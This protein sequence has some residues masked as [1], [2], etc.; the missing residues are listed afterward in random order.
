LQRRVH[1]RRVARHAIVFADPICRP[2][3]VS[4]IWTI[5]AHRPQQTDQAQHLVPEYI[6]AA[7]LG[8]VFVGIAKAREISGYRGDLV[9]LRDS[10]ADEHVLLIVVQKAW[11]WRR[12]TLERELSQ[13]PRAET[14]DGADIGLVESDGIVETP[15]ADEPGTYA[16]F[17]L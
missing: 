13:Q 17:Q 9:S 7:L 3:C 14:M 10:L 6:L 2:G 4:G 5:P 8:R 12:A 16:F 15:Q 1:T 11:T